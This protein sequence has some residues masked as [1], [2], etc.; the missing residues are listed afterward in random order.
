MLLRR[1]YTRFISASP[2]SVPSFTSQFFS[3]GIDPWVGFV[4]FRNTH[5]ISHMDF[6]KSLW[7][8]NA[9]E[10]LFVYW[11]RTCFWIS[12][13]CELAMLMLLGTGH[14]KSVSIRLNRT[15]EV[16]GPTSCSKQGQCWLQTGSPQT[17]FTSDLEHLTS[18]HPW[19]C[20]HGYQPMCFPQLLNWWRWFMCFTWFK[21]S[22]FPEYIC[23]ITS[24]PYARRI[25][26]SL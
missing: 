20:L 6:S 21:L 5:Q 8:G 13:N 23:N 15:L 10:L 19:D 14:F 7:K 17:L 2:S 26:S 25:F 4:F 18:H 9:C 1:Y 16:S 24:D 11:M 12:P 3:S 22:I